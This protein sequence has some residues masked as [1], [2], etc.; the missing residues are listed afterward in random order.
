MD[1]EVR[2][3]CLESFAQTC[4]ALGIKMEACEFGPDHVHLF[5]SR[6]KNYSVPQMVQRLRRIRPQDT[7]RAVGARKGEAVG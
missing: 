2:R 3:L 1:E 7:P 5:V 4:F 6:C